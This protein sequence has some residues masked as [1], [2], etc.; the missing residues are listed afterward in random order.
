M[1]AKIGK[2]LKFFKLFG[3]YYEDLPTSKF[4]FF[5]IQISRAFCF[6]L[7][8]FF[9]L[10]SIYFAFVVEIFSD[11]HFAMQF[12]M[13]FLILISGVLNLIFCYKNR[14]KEEKILENLTEA[15]KLIE[16]FLEI[17]ISWK[18]IKRKMYLKVFGQIMLTFAALLFRKIYTG[19]IYFFTEFY[20]PTSDFSVLLNRIFF[21]K[22]ILYVDLMH[23]QL[24]VRNLLNFSLILDSFFV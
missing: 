21:A 18:K 24:M 12:I 22:F 14:K 15:S 1:K 11:Y 13:N 16:D 2:L 7:L 5:L 19:Q 8:F 20:T 17:K 6:L 4:V 3:V 10:Q 23:F 9:I